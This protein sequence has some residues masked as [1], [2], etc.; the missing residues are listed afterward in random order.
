MPS[1][2]T[3]AHLALLTSLL[4]PTKTGRRRAVD[5]REVRE[6]WRQKAIDLGTME[7]P[8]VDVDGDM[9]SIT[10]AGREAFNGVK[11]QMRGGQP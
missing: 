6:A 1:V 3:P 9:V 11:D 2:L 10:D 5:L 4:M 8:L 7:P